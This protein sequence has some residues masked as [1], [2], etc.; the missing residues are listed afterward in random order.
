[1]KAKT[2]KS[3][4]NWTAPQAHDD[5]GIPIQAAGKYQFL[6]LE[7]YNFCKVLQEFRTPKKL[8]VAY[9]PCFSVAREGLLYP[10][11][12]L[13][14]Q[15]GDGHGTKKYATIYKVSQIPQE[16]IREL[17]ELLTLAGL[18]DYVANSHPFG[19]PNDAPLAMA[20]IAAW[21]DCFAQN[22]TI[23]QANEPRF[24]LNTYFKTIQ[25]YSPHIEVPWAHLNFA[26]PLYS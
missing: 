16:D 12:D 20:A 18:P 7:E 26:R 19:L 24:A 11:I 17:R 10:E 14:Y 23:A 22:N 2:Y 9:V 13:Y 6:G 15:E 21:K 8:R 25:F 1:M 4:N 5:F 3:T